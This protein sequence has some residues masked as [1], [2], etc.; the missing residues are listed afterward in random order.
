MFDQSLIARRWTSFDFSATTT[1][2][3][4]PY[5]YHQTAG[6][7]CFYNTKVFYY[8]YV[9][10]DEVKKQRI[11]NISMNDNFSFSEPLQGKYVYVDDEVNQISLKVTVN[12]DKL[13]FYYAFEDGEFTA[14]GPVLDASII[15]DEHV[16]G[17]TYTG[18]VVGI[19]TVD[20]FN[21]DTYALF[22]EFYQKNND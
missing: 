3:F 9:G 2:S 13:Q 8:L 18:A 22:R 15:S 11:I 5:H 16:S 1:L 12:Q 14:I 17:W 4:E 7:T 19:T 10:Y 6:L 20:N 21:K